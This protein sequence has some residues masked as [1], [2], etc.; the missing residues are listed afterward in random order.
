MASTSRPVRFVMLAFAVAACWGCDDTMTGPTA[1][2]T[3]TGP[4]PTPSAPRLVYV[5]QTLQGDRANVFVDSVS[6]TSVTTMPAGQSIQWVWLSGVHSTTSGSCPLGCV[7]NGI[8]DSG[9]VSATTFQH[10]FPTAGTYPY[11][12]TVHGTMMQ[13][14]VIVQ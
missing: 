1:T 11:F 8:W 14:T 7:A 3:P 6:G 5:G 2:P 4:T 9:A 10:T 12:C 13:G